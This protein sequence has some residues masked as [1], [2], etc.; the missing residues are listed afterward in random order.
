MAKTEIINERRSI[1]KGQ[2][3]IERNTKTSLCREDIEKEL[4]RITFDQTKIKTQNKRLIEQ[5]NI[6]EEKKKELQESIKDLPKEE[7]ETIK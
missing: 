7:I 1:E 3:I 2:I 4:F 5:Y 6:L